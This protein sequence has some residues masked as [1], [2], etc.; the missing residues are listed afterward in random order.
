MGSK[1]KLTMG[2]AAVQIWH[3]KKNC[4]YILILVPHC[5]EMR[6][7]SF[8]YTAIYS[9]TQLLPPSNHNILIRRLL[10]L[11]IHATRALPGN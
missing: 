2:G 7:S 8:V 5:C 3:K 4:L 10:G 11:E 1:P 9:L 6:T